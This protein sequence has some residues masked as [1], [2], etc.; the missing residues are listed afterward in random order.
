MTART[1]PFT[2]GPFTPGMNTRRPDFKMSVVANRMRQS[3]VRSAVNADLTAEGSIKRRGGYTLI[4]TGSNC[5]SLWTN[6][7]HTVGYYVDGNNLVEIGGTPDALHTRVVRSGLAGGRVLSFSDTNNGIYYSDGQELRA[8]IGGIDRVA[9]APML[10]AEPSITAGAGGALAAGRYELC[11][12]YLMDDGRQS[13]STLPVSLDTPANG[14]IV[15]DG[16]P[17][18]WPAGVV[19]LLIHMTALNSTTLLHALTLDAPTASVTIS[20]M[21]VLGARCPTVMLEPMPAG[22]IV[23]ASNNRLLVANGPFVYYS[24]PFAYALHKPLKNYIPFPA[25]VTLIVTTP[26]GVFIAADQTYYLEGDIAL[27]QM[28]TLLPYGAVRGTSATVAGSNDVWWMSTRG[29]VVG[30]DNGTVENLQEE[31]VAIGAADAG[32]SLYREQD[33]MKQVI[34][35][36]FGTHPTELAAHSFMDAEIVRQG[37][38]L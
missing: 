22:S 19:G 3:F 27:A 21:P 14:A 5:H 18:T 32:A 29:V 37:V 20:S 8:I 23:C 12:T 31:N 16:L 10:A 26:Y 36:L 4:A 7:A 28:K 15:L 35:S 13:G 6:D 24:E 17:S 34:S 30:H 11:C 38:I 25:D 33:G 9:G 2:M 1:K